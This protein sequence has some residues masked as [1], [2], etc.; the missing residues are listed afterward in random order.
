MGPV[1][2]PAEFTG[3]RGIIPLDIEGEQI[4][5]RIVGVVNRFPSIVGD[6]VVAELSQAATR[7]DVLSPGLGTP[8]EL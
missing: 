3:P 2:P 5:G 4:A 1:P 7:L 6:A 8:D